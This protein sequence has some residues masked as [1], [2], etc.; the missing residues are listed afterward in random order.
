M[1]KKMTGRRSK[2]RT[3]SM[4]LIYQNEMYSYPCCQQL[5]DCSSLSPRRDC[6]KPFALV[7]FSYWYCM[8]YTYCL[9]LC[10]LLQT[11][12]NAYIISKSSN[13]SLYFCTVLL[14]LLLSTQVTKSSIP[15]VTKNAG[16]VTT[17]GPTRTC[18]CSMNVIAIL[19]V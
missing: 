19:G 6:R 9:H 13:L 18:P 10:I 12:N 8:H 7:F 5:V 14:T 3:N 2:E 16:S 17:F 11:I 4:Y 1:A 15:L